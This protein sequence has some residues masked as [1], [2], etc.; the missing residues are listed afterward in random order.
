MPAPT[1]KYWKVT[2]TN[3]GD[4]IALLNQSGGPQATQLTSAPF[5]LGDIEAGMWAVPAVMLI[6]F[7]GSTAQCLDFKMYD[8]D[9]NT[10]SPIITTLGD[11]LFNNYTNDPTYWSQCYNVHFDLKKNWLD[12]TSISVSPGSSPIDNWGEV[13]YGGSP[14][15]LDTSSRRPLPG[16]DGTNGLLTTTVAGDDTRHV[17]NF[18]LYLSIKPRSAAAAGEHLGFGHRLSYVYP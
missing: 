17:I 10:D 9:Q 1:V 14:V 15:R 4:T 6:E 12:P 11:D 16:N 5:D 3:G 13:L 8:T 18:F 2:G 7:A